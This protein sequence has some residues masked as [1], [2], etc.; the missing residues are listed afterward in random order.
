MI[1]VGCCGFCVSQKEY[2]KNFE[3]IE[4]QKT[5]YQ[6]PEKNRA[7]KWKKSAP[8]DF[9]FTL[10]AWQIITH[11]A[12][13]PTYRKLNLKIRN[14][15][16]IGFFKPTDEVFDAWKKTEE[17]AKILGTKVVVFQTP[18]SFQANKENIENLKEFFITIRDKNYI[19]CWEPRGDWPEELIGELC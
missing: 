8:S 13:S 3:A 4:I 5:F 16:N 11:P 6:L 17:I 12:D 18:S 14:E 1:K 15:K 2:F 7:L 10:K 19:F 9:E